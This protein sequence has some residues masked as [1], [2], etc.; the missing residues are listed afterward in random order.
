MK[1]LLIASIVFL[2]LIS[3]GQDYKLFNAGSKKLFT[4]YPIAG[5]SS[6]IEFDSVI[7]AGNDSIFITYTGVGNVIASDTCEF[8]GGLIVSNRTGHCGLD[9]GFTLIV[10]T[11]ILSSL[12]SLIRWFSISTCFL[13]IHPCFIMMPQNCFI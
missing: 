6:G 13:A 11:R 2:S 12:V 7:V 3:T 1:Y 9:P 5:I 10:Q 4:S 8:W